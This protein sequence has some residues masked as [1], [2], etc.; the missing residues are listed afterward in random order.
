MK[1]LHLSSEKSWRGGE[2]QIAYLV[3]FSLLNEIEIM[4]CCRKRSAF[5][6]WCSAHNIPFVEAG[7]K[8]GFDLSTIL[9]IKQLARQQN[10]DFVH[11]HSGKSQSLAF[12]AVKT[13]MKTPIIAHRRVDVPLKSSGFSNAKYNHRCTKA[14]VCVSKNIASVV[15]PK[16][17]FPD[18]IKVVYSGIDFN[19]F[20]QKPATGYLHKEYGI[21]PSKKLVANISALAP[22]KD[23]TTFI[24]VAKRVLTERNDCCFLIVGEG[25]EQLKL[26]NQINDAG[27][28][29]HI[30]MTGFRKDVALLLR[31]LHLFM[32]TSI[33]EGL[34][35]TV[36]DALYNGLP[37][38]ATRG[39]GIP[40]L[41]TE[42][43]NGFLCEVKDAECLATK[44]NL[45]LSDGALN[46]KLSENAVQGAQRFSR[47]NMGRG[48][49]EVYQSL[50]ERHN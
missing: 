7:F 40:E 33:T 3:E 9:R 37:V 8:N 28:S 12:L 17:T 38:V 5:S 30:I 25:V 19:R 27:L 32:I 21:D 20:S 46:K 47:E 22:H 42:A 18:K 34:G 23:F 4:V 50:Q 31:E 6:K 29:N 45:L 36:I 11:T 16:I 15:K 26:K 24:K 48:V 41:I 10:I 35:T 1:V 14:I 39:G 49:L 43:K 2:Q 44:A 13:G